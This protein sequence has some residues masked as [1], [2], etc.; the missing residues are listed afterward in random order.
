M[1]DLF[2]RTLSRGVLKTDQ[3]NSISTASLDS[4][5]YLLAVESEN[6][7]ALLKL[8]IRR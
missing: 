2:G 4:G 5:I 8:V 1:S 6:R 7:R 3:A